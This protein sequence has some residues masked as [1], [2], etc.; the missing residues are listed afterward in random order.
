[1]FKHLR[2]DIA[3]LLSLVLIAAAVLLIFPPA[4]F[5][6]I[7]SRAAAIAVFV[8]GFWATA[9]IPEYQTALFFF[10]I[11]V[12]LNVSPPNV[13]F[14]G[15]ASTALWLIFG[16][17]II[18]EGI[19]STGL[20]NR[21]AGSIVTHF[22]GR[23]FYLIGGVLITGML[24]A[25]L[26]PGA[27]GRVILLV[28][29]VSAV[30][31]HV[32]FEKGSNGRIG[33]MLAAIF[34]TI[35]PAF[36]ILPSNVPNMVFAGMVE[37][38][39]GVS[40]LY[41]E[42]FWLHFPILGLLKAVA[43][44]ALILW[45]FPDCPGKLENKNMLQTEPVSKNEKILTAILLIQIALW[46]TDFIHHIS[47]AWIALGGALILLLP[48]ISVV[49]KRQFSDNINFSILFFVAGII[50][51]GGM[52]YDT[53]LGQTLANQLIT[54]LPLAENKPFANYLLMSLVSTLTGIVVTVTGIPAVITPFCENLANSSGFALK[55]VLM[56]QV[57][58]FSTIILPYQLA[59]MVIGM[60]MSGEKLSSAIKLCLSLLFVTIVLLLPLNF[61]WWQVLGWI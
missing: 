17:L 53:G 27:I 38:R 52:V 31:E 1:M 57:L 28:P 14:S 24:F 3:L 32:G 51:L 47:P 33:V 4:S 6:T 12:L 42:Y 60:Q 9:V 50:G 56:T 23:Y 20:G 34:G 40:I 54:L 21:I 19:S 35:M 11:A 26:M 30:A 46:M 25:F 45:L 44:V 22:T 49:G 15:F 59:P 13:I 61:L 41:G 8:I 10:L 58:G 7:E 37:T 18:A 5:S 36:A 29:F 48:K 16:G 43:I 55:S 39:Y 2:L